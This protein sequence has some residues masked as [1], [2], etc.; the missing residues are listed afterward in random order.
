MGWVWVSVFG[1]GLI[2]LGSGYSPGFSGIRLHHYIGHVG[3]YV[4]FSAEHDDVVELFHKIG[5]KLLFFTIF[6]SE[7]W[8][9]KV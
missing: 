3:Y 4:G 5:T 9:R 7:I 8:M 6:G 1:S 2:L